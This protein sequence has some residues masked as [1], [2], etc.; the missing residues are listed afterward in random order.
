[1]SYLTISEY[2]QTFCKYDAIKIKTTAAYQNWHQL[3]KN[4]AGSKLSSNYELWPGHITI[5]LQC[6]IS[7]ILSIAIV[8]ALIHRH[9]QL[10]SFSILSVKVFSRFFKFQSI[11]FAKLCQGTGST[12]H[13]K[14]VR[15]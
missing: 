8:A 14:T 2:Q 9:M 11:D 10:S 4:C 15:P 12:H 7:N 1:M 13:Q 5:K 3:T 6:F